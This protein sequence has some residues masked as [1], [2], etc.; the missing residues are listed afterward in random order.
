VANSFGPNRAARAAASAEL[1]PRC[2]STPS[3]CRT[4]S[5]PSVC[6]ASSP[7]AGGRPVPISVYPSLPKSC[8]APVIWPVPHRTSQSVLP[9]P[10]CRSSPLWIQSDGNA[11]MTEP[12][13]GD[14]SWSAGGRASRLQTA[15]VLV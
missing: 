9:K 2:P 8:G 3:E 6:H 1:R 5:A 14:R 15:A 10:R 11:R 4:W 12:G 13:A 7:S